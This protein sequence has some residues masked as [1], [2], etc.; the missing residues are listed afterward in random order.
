MLEP[1][2]IPNFRTLVSKAKKI[3]IIS[4]KNP[5]GD[6]AGSSL[7]LCNFLKFKLIRSTVILPDTYPGFLRF[8]PGT[9]EVIYYDLQK[10]RAAKELRD[11]DL[12]FCLDFNSLK[13]ADEMGEIVAKSKAV[14]IMIDHHP[15]PDDFSDFRHHR[16]NVSSTSELVYEFCMQ[17]F[18]E[19]QMNVEAATCLY[20]GI[21][22]DT[23]S[24]KFNVHPNT[25]A[26]AGELIKAGA[27]YLTINRQIY[28]SNSLNRTR[29]LGFVLK[30]KLT[31]LP[32][33]G[34]AYIPLS[35]EEMKLYDHKKGDTEGFVNYAL[36]VAGVKMAVI[37]TEQNENLTK[38][39][40]RSFGDFAV[41]GYAGKYFSGGGHLNAA[42]GV[43][44]GNLE[45]AL[46]KFGELLKA[47]FDY[48]IQ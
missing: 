44:Y 22:T 15:D 7:G 37:F 30:D 31:V 4:H 47:E 23:G 2:T 1:S 39:S 41:N 28:D 3:V 38:L 8:L 42:G 46:A 32:E 13:R 20:A 34:V 5:D 26:V 45:A 16:V 6:A 21:L 9:K 12:I 19:V 36:G 33:I 27:E 11:A 18:P 35:Q 29:L 48:E 10:D 14:K 25:H 24:F 17:V 40:F 43:F